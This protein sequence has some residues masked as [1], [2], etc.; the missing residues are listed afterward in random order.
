MG[1]GVL[2]G[3]EF[4][5]MMENGR[6]VVQALADGLKV[7]IGA[8]RSMAEQGQLTAEVVIQALEKQSNAIDEK[9][10]KKGVTVG[11]AMQN[12]QTNALCLLVR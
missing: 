4:N 12:M 7:P 11:Q 3:D 1:S 6:G 8:L 2:R 9:F 5:S 10:V